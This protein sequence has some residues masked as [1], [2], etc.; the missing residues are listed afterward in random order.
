MTMLPM[1]FSIVAL[2]ISLI[3]VP[4]TVWAFVEL[5]S[6]KKSTHR[7]QFVPAEPSKE[8]AVKAFMEGLHQDTFIGDKL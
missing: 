6:F 5:M 4:F 7:V 8:D 3:T 1:I 2:L